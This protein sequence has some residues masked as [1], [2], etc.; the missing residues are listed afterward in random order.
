MNISSEKKKEMLL[1][2]FETLK[3]NYNGN[4]GVLCDLIGKMS[5]IDLDIAIEMWKHLITNNLKGSR[6]TTYFSIIDLVMYYIRQS[7]G[8]IKTYSIVVSDNM[9][10][11]AIFHESAYIGQCPA[12]VIGHLIAKNDLSLANELLE[13]IHTNKY[14]KTSLYEIMNEVIPQNKAITEEAF[15]LL[16]EWISKVNKSE[17][18]TKLNIKMLSFMNDDEDGDYEQL[19]LG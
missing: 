17:E 8:E 4:S 18:R 12:L 1:D 13:L 2:A 9:L 16:S 6:S 7:I 5:K 11:N 19:T 15:G 3:K 10:K 14:R